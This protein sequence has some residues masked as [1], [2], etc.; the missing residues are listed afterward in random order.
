MKSIK[1]MVFI[2]SLGV[3]GA[4]IMVE[5]LIMGLR[6][7]VDVILVTFVSVNSP[8]E[9]R[10]KKYNVKIV[11]INKPLGFSMKGLLGVAKITKRE[12]PNVV[13]THLHTLPYVWLTN[14]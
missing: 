8:I 5:N 9:Q 6:K 14:I 12:R 11:C 7:R 1:V 2:P 3:G 13:H 4:E 10:L